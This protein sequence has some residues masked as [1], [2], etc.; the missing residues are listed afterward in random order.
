ML[1]SLWFESIIKVRLMMCLLLPIYCAKDGLARC[2]HLLP[3]I[4]TDLWAWKDADPWDGS[5]T[6]S[7]ESRGKTC[8]HVYVEPSVFKF[9]RIQKPFEGWWKARCAC[10]CW[11]VF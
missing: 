1:S 5:L 4:C 2:S 11:A 8:R 7:K 10:C 9:W 6:I 3:P